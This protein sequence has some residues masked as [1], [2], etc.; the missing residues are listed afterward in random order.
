MRK[1]LYS[2]EAG[3]S[4]IQLQKHYSDFNRKESGTKPNEKLFS[5][6]KKNS[7]NSSDI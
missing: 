5:S 1:N 7:L 4:S 2:S 6:F 3:D